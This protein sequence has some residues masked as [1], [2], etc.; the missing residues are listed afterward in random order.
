LTRYSLR[1]FPVADQH[2]PGWACYF[3]TN[4]SA[5]H[6]IV[7][8]VWIAQGG[9]N[10]ILIDTG[11]PPDP[12]DFAVLASACAQMDPRCEFR[13]LAPLEAVLGEAGVSPE[14]IDLVLITQPITYHSGG[15]L[16]RLLPKARVYLPRA[17]VLEFLLDNPG[18]PPRNCYFTESAWCFLRQL[19]LENRLV[20]TDGPVEVAPGVF[21]ETTGGHHPGSAAVKM[22]TSRGTVGILETAFL[23][24]NIEKEIPI[25]LAESA[26]ECRTA[27]RAY[28]AACDLLFA[29]HDSTITGRFSKG[30]IA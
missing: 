29:I 28:K 21:F 10:T 12:D 4:D 16:P 2:L 27:I 25:G 19:L 23:A 1:V 22:A 9:G 14:S 5:L 18:H 26:A 7:F 11:P 24:D 30:V 13:S 15:L 20:L 3:G 17:G 6:R 8:H